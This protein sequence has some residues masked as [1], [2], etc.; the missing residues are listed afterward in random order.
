[1]F[2][3][4]GIGLNTRQL[5]FEA[6]DALKDCNDI[7]IDNYTNIFSK[8][9]LEDLEKTI[10]KKIIKLNRSSLES[11]LCFLKDNSC[12]LVIGNP[13]SA[14]THFTL[15]EEARKRNLEVKII[16]GI[17]IFN[18]R[19]NT[20]LF[21]YKF[22]KTTTIVYPLKNYAPTSFYDIIL[23]NLKIGAHSFC[24]L[25]I[26]VLNNKIMN[27]KDACEI[28]EK[29]DTKKT[30]EKKICIALIAAASKEEEAIVF[31][32]KDYYKLNIK[33]Y[34]QT[35]IICGELNDF[36]REAIKWKQM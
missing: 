9:L 26:D 24:L 28:L 32:F 34:P 27:V 33:K 8:G 18:Y 14:T 2:Y 31:E 25:D 21:E 4:I 1:M 3:I 16:P 5:T 29:I 36:E 30:L 11:D 13:F 15:I 6:M 19:G 7:Y 35:L 23:E 22:G 10:S 20:G 12:L 17:S